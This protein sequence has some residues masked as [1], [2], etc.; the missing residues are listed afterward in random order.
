[1][2]GY[3]RPL[4]SELKVRELAQ[5]EAAYCGLCHSLGKGFGP[6]S[7]F[8]LNYDLTFLSILLRSGEKT[9]RFERR[10][11]A[12]SPFR[13]KCV[14]CTGGDADICAAYSVILVYLKL[15]DSLID[16][17][18]FRSLPA[19][20]MRAL[21]RGAYDKAVKRSGNFAALALDAL[22]ELHELEA[23]RSSSIDRTADSFARILAAA[24]E[25]EK[26]ENVRRVLSQILYH[27]GRWVY[28]VDARCDAAEDMR[29][30]RYNPLVSRF[31]ISG[32]EVPEVCDRELRITL[33]NSRAM[34][35]SAFELLPEGA[36][37]GIIG[38]ILYA[39]MEQVTEDV[40]SGAY[41][42]R[43]K[44]KRTKWRVDE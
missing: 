25:T 35:I 15:E 23:A 12:V 9:A 10:R 19:R 39:G 6:L 27:V 37:T 2:F 14:A 43:Q 1:M 38:N 40:F 24:A 22:R 34:M 36:W 41:R 26:D 8:T 30:G 7:R 13:K 17:G 5:F 4:K 21:L 29:A 32:G 31:G 33:A 28:I 3:V 16:E 42:H 18:F 44:R 20:L 11:C